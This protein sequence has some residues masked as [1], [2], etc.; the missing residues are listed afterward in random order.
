[1]PNQWIKALLIDQLAATEVHIVDNSHRHAGHAA[2]KG[3]TQSYGT[4]LA[5]VVVSP[6]FEGVPLLD[7]HRMV[8]QVL[9]PAYERGLH[10]LELKVYT[11]EQWQALSPRPGQQQVQQQEQ[12]EQGA[13]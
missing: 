5:M 9:E 2:M 6:Q 3:I 7:R 10:A 8:H 4:H 13:S 11:P 1:M 12:Q